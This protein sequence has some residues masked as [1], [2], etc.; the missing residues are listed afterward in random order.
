MWYGVRAYRRKV[1]TNGIDERLKHLLA[2][3]CQHSDARIE[4][5]EVMPDQGHL[6]VNGDPQFGVHRLVKARKAVV[7]RASCGKSIHRS[8]LVRR[9]EGPIRL[10]LLP[11][12]SHHL[13]SSNTP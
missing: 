12:A 1:L 5:L 6:L 4:E 7:R 9:D 13:S 8:A 10:L 11:R 2:E 3:G